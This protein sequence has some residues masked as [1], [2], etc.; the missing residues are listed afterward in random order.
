MCMR[1]LA[2]IERADAL[3]P[4]NAYVAAARGN[5]LARMGNW[6]CSEQAVRKGLKDHP[7][8]P[9]LLFT[10]AQLLTGVGRCN[11]AIPLFDR[12]RRQGQPNPG[13]Y[14]REIVALWSAN[15]LDEADQMMDD[16]AEL[17]PSQ[18]AIWFARLYIRM[19]SGR[20]AAAMAMIEDV[21]SRPT[22][23]PIKEFDDLTVVI[24]AF[25]SRARTDIDRA[26]ELW[27]GRART[28][29]GLAENSLQ[30]ASFLG[31]LDDAF[32]IADAYFFGRG[33][34]V[35]EIRFNPEQATYTRLEERI[36]GFLFNPATAA[37]RADPRFARLTAEIGLDHYWQQAGVQPDYR[38]R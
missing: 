22:G 9:E 23:I 33:F 17:Y 5:V 32:A 15:R 16:A 3:D 6:F 36:T 18:F 28:G 21:N 31:R 38:R 26:M 1:V 12:I 2:A 37:M 7:D 29:A 11:E 8:N 14:F 35:A 24:R 34:A 19:Y 20:A 4:H 30:F 25:L 27:L 13:F 10:L